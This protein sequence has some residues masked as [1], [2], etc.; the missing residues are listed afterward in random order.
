MPRITATD[1]RPTPPPL[2]EQIA[3][4]PKHRKDWLGV[5]GNQ[6]AP[7]KVMPGTCEA[8]VWNSGVHTCGAIEDFFTE[9]GSVSL[10]P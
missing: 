9:P 3:K 4:L 2:D 10:Y 6:W 1:L 5:F 7:K 8:C